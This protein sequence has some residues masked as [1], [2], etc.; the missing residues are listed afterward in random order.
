LTQETFILD[1]E[2]IPNPLHSF[3]L[4]VALNDDLPAGNRDYVKPQVYQTKQYPL[5]GLVGT[6]EARE[7]TE[8]H[9]APFPGATERDSLLNTNVVAW[10]NGSRVTPVIP[11]PTKNG[12]ASMFENCLNASSYVVFSNT[13]SAAEWNSDHVGAL[14]VSNPENG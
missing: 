9:N 4:P 6:E 13:T 11:N 5:S 7:K 8:I 12:I 3:K 1:G 14:V 10:L 2:S